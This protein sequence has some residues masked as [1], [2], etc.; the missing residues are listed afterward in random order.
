MTNSLEVLVLESEPGAAASA[1]DDLQRAGH[2]VHRCHEPGR[3]AFPC[4]GLGED[5]CPLDTG[6]VDVALTVRGR[7]RSVPSLFEDGVS[8]ALQHR[9]PLVVAGR[10][11]LNPYD[12]FATAVVDH[13]ADVVAAVETAASGSLREH[14]VLASD[15]ARRVLALQGAADVEVSATAT[16]R[17]GVVMVALRVGTAIDTRTRD[18]IGTRALAALRGFDRHARQIDVS[19]D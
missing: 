15:A 6:T 12:E 2:Q 10:V 16:R 17:R 3:P 9:I 5:G 19:I 7:P 4:R 14:E 1:V 11:A 8:C 13:Q 18:L